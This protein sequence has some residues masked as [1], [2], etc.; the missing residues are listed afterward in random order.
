MKY[1]INLAILIAALSCKAGTETS[2]LSLKTVATGWQGSDIFVWTKE[3][4]LVEDCSSSVFIMSSSHPM[5]SEILSILLSAYHSESKV[6]LYVDG[7]TDGNMNLQAIK[8]LK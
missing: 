3:N 8:L 1:V 7:C 2:E 6:R 5:K 4:V